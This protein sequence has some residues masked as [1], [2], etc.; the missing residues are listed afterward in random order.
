MKKE[1]RAALPPLLVEPLRALGRNLRAARQARGWTIAEAAARCLVSPAT[2]KRMEAG[3]PSVAIGTW[4]TALAQCQLL[5]AWVAATAPQVDPLGEA[6]RAR[7]APRRVRKP[8]D[9]DSR[10]DF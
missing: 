5:D 3:E 9:E 4:A 8:V 6:L 10:Y 2:Y 1:A 7:R